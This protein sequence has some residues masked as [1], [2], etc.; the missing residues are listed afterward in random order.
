MS[1]VFYEL[2][3]INC[4]VRLHTY[5][6]P[7]ILSGIPMY[8]RN[9]SSR[10]GPFRRD[11]FEAE[12]ATNLKSANDGHMHHAVY[13]FI[14]NACGTGELSVPFFCARVRMAASR[15]QWPTRDLLHC[16]DASI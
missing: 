8:K 3:Q 4:I 2:R 5:I 10:Q 12:N 7:Y 6:Y 15:A 16:K 14:D 11:S 9:F 13:K 1:I